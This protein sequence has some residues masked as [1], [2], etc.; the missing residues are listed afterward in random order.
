MPNGIAL[1]DRNGYEVLGNM[2][3]KEV[4]KLYD[5]IRGFYDKNYAILVNSDG[6][7]AFCCIDRTGKEIVPC[8]YLSQR[9]AE[10]EL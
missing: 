7:I 8:I 9:V 1:A 10:N 2:E 3:A 5:E 6:D 4:S